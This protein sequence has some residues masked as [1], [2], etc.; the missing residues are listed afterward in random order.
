MDAYLSSAWTYPNGRCEEDETLGKEGTCSKEEDEEERIIESELGGAISDC[1]AKGRKNAVVSSIRLLKDPVYVTR[2]V[3]HCSS[4]GKGLSTPSD[5]NDESEE[6]GVDEDGDMLVRRRKR[7]SKRRRRDT[8]DPEATP[9]DTSTGKRAIITPSEV[10]PLTRWVGPFL[11]LA[12]LAYSLRKSKHTRIHRSSNCPS[13]ITQTILTDLHRISIESPSKHFSAMLGRTIR[14]HHMRATPLPVVGLQLWIGS[15]VLADYLLADPKIIQGKTVLELG[16]GSGFLGILSTGLRPKKY[17][18]TDYE[19]S[20]LLNAEEN[21]RISVSG[22][23]ASATSDANEMKT[24]LEKTS[25][26]SPPSSGN[27]STS[28]SSGPSGVVAIR[29]LDWLHPP[30]HLRDPPSGDEDKFS[31]VDVSSLPKMRSAQNPSED[32]KTAR[33]FAEISEDELRGVD[34]VLGSDVVYDPVLTDALACLLDKIVKPGTLAIISAEKRVYFSQATLKEEV[35]EW[36]RFIDLLK[37][38]GMQVK[39]ATLDSIPRFTENER[40]PLLDIIEVRRC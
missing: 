37:V 5:E 6:E 1:N 19:D 30:E 34:V 31:D 11:T 12:H 40:N 38:S 27:R 20:I 7:P 18:L 29:Q 21:V 25:S 26:G 16:C 14:I 2:D 23:S 8:G 10:H 35:Y 24:K 4:T 39:H 17:F 22:S 3:K 33:R 28:E 15:M 36:P 13:R 9:S 32:L